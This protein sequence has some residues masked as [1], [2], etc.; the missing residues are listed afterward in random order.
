MGVADDLVPVLKKLRLSGARL[1]NDELLDRFD[2]D[3]VLRKRAAE[4]VERAR[5]RGRIG[6][7]R[8]IRAVRRSLEETE[9]LDVP[10]ERG[11]RDVET[12]RRQVLAQL[13]LAPHRF[14]LHDVENG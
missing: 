7:G 12:A 8:L 5:V 6:A 3:E 10:R 9:L 14:V 13:F 11:L 1:E 2:V 4:R